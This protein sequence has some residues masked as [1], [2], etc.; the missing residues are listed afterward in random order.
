MYISVGDI[1]IVVNLSPCPLVKIFGPDENYL[2]EI[3]EFV[4]G[5]DNPKFVESYSVTSNQMKFPI[6]QLEFKLPIEFYMDYDITIYKFVDGYG[7][8]NIFNHR[9]N[10][11]NKLV[12]FNLVTDDIEECE[13]W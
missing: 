13:M 8:K 11:T 10:D 7:I 5:D 3:N 4:D 6:S 1:K 12:L 2:I 9:Y